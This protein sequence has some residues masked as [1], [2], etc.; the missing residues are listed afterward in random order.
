[1]TM[2]HD[3]FVT[4]PS[5]R[6]IH[7]DTAWNLWNMRTE[8]ERTGTTVAE[9]AAESGVS[10]EVVRKV[11][12]TQA[13][14]VSRMHGSSIYRCPLDLARNEGVTIFLSTTADINQCQDD[15]VQIA[16]EW[17]PKMIAALETDEVDILTAPCR[18]RSE[19]NLFNIIPLTDPVMVAGLN[20]VECAWTGFGCVLIKR[21]VLETLFEREPD[22]YRSTHMP[23]KTSA[24]IFRSGVLPAQRFFIEAPADVNNYVLDDRIFSVKALEAGFKIH[25]AIDVPTIHDGMHGCFSEEL[26]RLEREDDERRRQTRGPRLVGPDGRA[27]DAKGGR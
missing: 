14:R 26:A 2:R 6:G 27:V 17:L 19:K 20:V 16:A 4:M 3:I 15:D 7:P 9:I 22:K 24:A 1:M 10:E 13:K 21:K 12:E 8:V 5:A 23:K 18:M 11:L 25:A